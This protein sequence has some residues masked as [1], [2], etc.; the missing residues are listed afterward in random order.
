MKDYLNGIIDKLDKHRLTSGFFQQ[1]DVVGISRQLL[2]KILVSGAQDVYTAGVIVE[3]EAYAGETDKA[4]HAFGGRRTA[5]TE[6]MYHEGGFAYVYLCYGVH[7][8]LNV[9]VNVPGVPHAILIRGAIP[10]MGKQTIE[11][12]IHRQLKF[13]ADCFGPGKITKQH[14]ITTRFNGEDLAG[15]HRLW[16]ADVSVAPRPKDIIMG[17][18]VGID[19]AEEDALLPYRFVWDHKAAVEEMKKAR[20][21]EPGFR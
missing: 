8:L 1:D 15:G 9:V 13:P 18:R 12:R 14:G 19:Y 3:T 4:S 2:G 7:A 5:R 10:F 11:S 21:F 17:P 16:L 20:L 6:I